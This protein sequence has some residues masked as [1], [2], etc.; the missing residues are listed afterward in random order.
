MLLLAG[1]VLPPSNKADPGA[2]I[3]EFAPVCGE[4]GI[5]YA[6]KCMAYSA[7]ATISYLGECNPTRPQNPCTNEHLPVCGNDG[8]TYQNTCFVAYSNT[9]ISYMGECG[10]DEPKEMSEALC[11]ASRGNWN[12]CGSA[13]RGA[14]EGTMCT[15]QCVQYCECGGIA[16]F[17]C[18]FGYECT[19]YLPTGAA[20][21]MGIC[22]PM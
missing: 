3:L 6:N 20:D 9:T 2:C 1:C 18:P 22:K 14:P 19:D 15:M 11:K 10:S 12:E 17:G 16:G 5:T 4:D 7:G 8:K 13:C 21:A